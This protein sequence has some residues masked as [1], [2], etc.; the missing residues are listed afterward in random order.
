[1]SDDQEARD[2]E[3]YFPRFTDEQIAASLKAHGVKM[4]AWGAKRNSVVGPVFFLALNGPDGAVG[5][6]ALNRAA[7]M[8]LKA[9]L[10]E[11]GF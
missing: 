11:A 10:Q 1:M 3:R 6:I 5:P 9:I 2:F 4:S 8:G 7:A